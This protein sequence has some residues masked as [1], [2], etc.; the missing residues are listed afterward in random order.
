[1]ERNTEALNSLTTVMTTLLRKI[2]EGVLDRQPNIIVL[3]EAGSVTN[4]ENLVVLNEGD[5]VASSTVLD[6]KAASNTSGSGVIPDSKPSSNTSGS[7]S[8]IVPDNVATS[9]PQQNFV[10][11]DIKISNDMKVMTSTII[12]IM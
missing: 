1:M 11:V 10:N 2:A 3:N 5:N 6:N 7:T 4:G 9:E 8:I 12:L